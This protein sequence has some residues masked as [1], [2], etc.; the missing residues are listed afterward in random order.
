MEKQTKQD[1]WVS[2]QF[3]KANDA[4][5]ALRTVFLNGRIEE[6]AKGAKDEK[7]FKQFIEIIHEAIDLIDTKRQNLDIAE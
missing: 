2:S 6:Y 4:I 1:A 7:A 3:D 5:D